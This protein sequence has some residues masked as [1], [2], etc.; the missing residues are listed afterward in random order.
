MVGTK[1][2]SLEKLLGGNEN[3]PILQL[4]ALSKRLEALST[5]TLWPPH[6]PYISF[7]VTFADSFL[8]ITKETY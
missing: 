3:P 1:V 8:N 7:L 5:R 2:A 4:K 6:R